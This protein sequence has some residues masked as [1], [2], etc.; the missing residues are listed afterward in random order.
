MKVRIKNDNDFGKNSPEDIN[1]SPKDINKMLKEMLTKNY[2]LKK[3]KR[4]Y[5][6]I[7]YK[8]VNKIKGYIRK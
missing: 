1:K 6:I 8:L 3:E 7:F 4:R 2:V 5:V